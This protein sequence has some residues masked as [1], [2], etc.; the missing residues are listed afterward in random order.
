MCPARSSKAGGGPSNRVTA[1]MCMWLTGPSCARKEASTAVSR[2]PLACA[3]A[4]S[5]TGPR[6]LGPTV[7]RTFAVLL[8]TGL[9]AGCGGDDA[10]Q[11]HTDRFDGARAFAFLQR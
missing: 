4:A 11:A 2:S 7:R 8:A 9:L 10:A 6:R 1:P 3:I 5:L